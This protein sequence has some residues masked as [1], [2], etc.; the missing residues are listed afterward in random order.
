MKKHFLIASIFAGLFLSSFFVSCEKEDQNINDYLLREQSELKNVRDIEDPFN[1]G[2]YHNLC[3]KEFDYYFGLENLDTMLYDSITSGI[4]K[5]KTD[6]SSYEDN[7]Y[8]LDKSIRDYAE[9]RND[10]TDIT[11]AN[12]E[13]LLFLDEKIN[14]YE[15]LE[16]VVLKVK[17]YINEIDVNNMSE[18]DYFTI[19]STGSIF[20]ESYHLWESKL[21]ENKLPPNIILGAMETDAIAY[22]DC[23]SSTDDPNNPW[24]N[25][26]VHKTCL[27]VAGY[28]SAYYVMTN[29]Y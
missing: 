23:C 27:K 28:A 6:I 5:V 12:Y 10:S 22:N 17:D 11:E 3:I 1:G 16:E 24:D 18:K 8:I 7:C 4:L 13:F 26:T 9:D 25:T 14:Q 21:R 19:V 29:L 15:N 20:I 2:Y